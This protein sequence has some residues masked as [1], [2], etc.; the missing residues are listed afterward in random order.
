MGLNLN[1]D[2]FRAMVGQSNYGDVRLGS[3]NSLEKVN[4]HFL[5]RTF[6]LFETKPSKEEN[7]RIRMLFLDALTAAGMSKEM[8]EQIRKDLGLVKGGD[9]E[10]P[11]S[12][13][14]IAVVLEKFD[15]DNLARQNGKDNPLVQRFGAM[16]FAD[17]K[18]MVQKLNATPNEVF[19]S[20]PDD[21]LEVFFN[22]YGGLFRQELAKSTFTS[23]NPEELDLEIGRRVREYLKDSVDLTTLEAGGKAFTQGKD[24]VSESRQGA[25][26][27]LED[28]LSKER[29]KAERQ[30]ADQELRMKCQK[31][32]GNFKQSAIEKIYKNS[33]L[34]PVFDPVS[35]KE[36]TKK[37]VVFN[38]G[39]EFTKDDFLTLTPFKSR[40]ESANKDLR[41]TLKEMAETIANDKSRNPMNV[42]FNKKVYVFKFVGE[43]NTDELRANC[44][45]NV[46]TAKAFVDDF[47]AFLAKAKGN[48]F[49]L[50]QFLSA[51]LAPGQGNA[52]LPGNTY[53]AYDAGTDCSITFDGDK[54]T[55]T[56]TQALEFRDTTKETKN[57]GFS[58][59]YHEDGTAQPTYLKPVHT[60]RPDPT[61]QDPNEFSIYEPPEDLISQPS[62]DS[63][64]KPP[65]VASGVRS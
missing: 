32:R 23:Q 11:L 63:I 59:D 10:K 52:R 8:T 15:A 14:T 16:K 7:R 34:V 38:T 30:A 42:Y 40:E 17:F 49:S 36:V 9:Y 5:Q 45:W 39:I 43:N 24:R 50:K 25:L 46:A 21:K 1:L 62:K 55:A 56:Y 61:T 37:A 57:Y 20:L 4:N 22:R 29:D 53:G 58:V 41:S 3:S 6:G 33:K 54:I 26:S 44:N 47:Q 2:S 18:R 28:I 65:E 12:R 51:C 60:P 27:D 48:E 35:G 13:R 19:V 64:P 31:V